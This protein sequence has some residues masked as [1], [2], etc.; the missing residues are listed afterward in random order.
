METGV[1]VVL[2]GYYMDIEVGW[3]NYVNIFVTIMKL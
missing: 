3:L 1:V 2:V